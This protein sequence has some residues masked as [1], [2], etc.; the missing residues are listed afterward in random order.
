MGM[1][2]PQC[3]FRN[4]PKARQCGACGAD[5][6]APVANQVGAFYPPRA[7]SRPFRQSHPETPMGWRRWLPLGHSQPLPPSQALE[8]QR[9]RR[10]FRR[11]V[12]L[13]AL[14]SLWGLVPGLGLLLERQR[15][16]RWLLLASLFCL[17][18]IFL[19]WRNALSNLAL[20]SLA[21]L[22]IYSVGATFFAAWQRRCLPPL[23]LAQQVSVWL[24]VVSALLWLYALG[25]TLAQPIGGIAHVQFTV[26]NDPV[27][28]GGNTLLF[29]RLPMHVRSLAISDYLIV[30]GHWVRFQAVPEGFVFQL[31]DPVIARLE[32]ISP[33]RTQLFI[34]VPILYGPNASM[35]RAVVPSE[36]VRGK[37]MAV[38]NPP[39]Q[40]RW[41]R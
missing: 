36:A 7:W 41:L 8:Q 39:P 34:A 24:F 14:R 2:C 37:V 29:S 17:L 25:I 27:I 16:G 12:A 23:S 15:Q 30:D 10:H 26:P 22:V 31:G 20:L 5:L 32:G 28:Q 38:I 33:D 1:K 35:A 9:E 13:I 6:E 3:G 18:L 40:R 11:L 4:L 19:C 21:A